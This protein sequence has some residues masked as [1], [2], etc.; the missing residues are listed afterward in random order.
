MK[1]EAALFKVV[2]H[3][4]RAFL[5]VSCPSGTN[6]RQAH[7]MVSSVEPER[8]MDLHSQIL[9]GT[10]DGVPA[11]TQ[12]SSAGNGMPRTVARARPTRFDAEAA[13]RTLISWA[14]DDP[15]RPGLVDTP[16]RV[17]R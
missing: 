11:S 1:L 6:P 16:S 17:V 15:A 14:G 8:P 5:P 7:P 13:V 9:D 10:D 12:G 3:R 2:R 4:V